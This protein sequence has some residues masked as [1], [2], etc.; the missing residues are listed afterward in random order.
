MALYKVKVTTGSFLLSGTC[1]CISVTL[2]GLQAQ[3]TK[4]ALDKCGTALLPGATDVYNI[5]EKHDLGD[6][7]LIRLHKEPFSFFPEDS[8]FCCQVT[9][10]SPKGKIYHFPCYRWIEGYITVELPEGTATLASADV[11]NPLLLK[12]RENELKEKRE[13]YKWKVY[14]KAFPRCIDV[15]D[16]TELDS[17]IKYSIT[18]QLNFA[19][20]KSTSV[21]EIKLKGF[22]GRQESW[23]SLED[24]RK[25]FWTHKTATSEYVS[26]H[27]KEDAFFGYQFLNGVD[28]M[29]IR[30]CNKIPD[31]FPVTDSMV[32][33]ILGPKTNLTAELERGKIFLVDYK[34]LEGIPGNILNGHKQYLAAPLCLLY[35]SPKD[36]MIPLAIQINQTPGPENPIFLPSDN[37]W[38][39][40]LAKMWVRSSNFSTHQALTHFL[41]T[42]V[43]A[44][45]F[46]IATLRQLPMSHPLYKLLIPH[47]RYTLQIN[48]LARERLIGP[49]GSF[50]QNTAIGVAGLA[51]VISRDMQSVTYT[52]ICIPDNLKSRE[53]ESL[54]NF[55]YRDDG[56][57]IWSA[58]NSYV[59]GIVDFYYKSDESI[60]K[61]Q[62]LQAWV[63]EIFKEG[64]LERESSGVPSYLQTR[65]EL[66]KYLTMIIFTS[67]AQHAAVNSGQFDFLGWMPNSPSSMRKPP[68]KT[69]G[70]ATL[71]S[72]LEI[73][74]EVGTTASSMVTV[75]LLSTEP[76]D[77]R[78]LGTFPDE[79]FTEEEPKRCIKAFQERLS[80]ISAEI[81]SRN[82][83][84]PLKYTYLNPK[85]VENS[86]SI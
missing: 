19:L 80:Q 15:G 51:E 65:P 17:N 34:I 21:L 26:Q 11:H 12:Q 18:K 22:F 9:V 47:H 10:E 23:K 50:D 55:Y 67:S 31:N 68:P 70:R 13:I 82:K 71:E 53:V 45:V 84:L 29:M 25:V 38:D 72:V 35:L 73:L 48:A 37:E 79:L 56:L 66:I 27:W 3:G 4:S 81:E 2:V 59:S 39:W 60:Q 41:R 61:D 40:L 69:K 49:G 62:E 28:P 8:W 75:R 44:E 16:V 64:F 14:H 58:I 1:D 57:K 32:A 63:R 83:S 77:M 43:F 85:V 7:Q 42:H 54:P 78:P 74:P 76:G 86:V 30:K 52:S 6:I 36:E 24:L 20:T 33:S 46:C 5:H